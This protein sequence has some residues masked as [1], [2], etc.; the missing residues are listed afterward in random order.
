MDGFNWRVVVIL[1]LCALVEVLGVICAGA[2]AVTRVAI[3]WAAA[4]EKR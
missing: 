2:I 3:A 4:G 1:P